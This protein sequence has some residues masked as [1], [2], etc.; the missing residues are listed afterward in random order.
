MFDSQDAEFTGTDS[1]PVRAI[2]AVSTH[3]GSRGVIHA[4]KPH[5]N[6]LITL[7]FVVTA[8]LAVAVVGM[9]VASISLGLF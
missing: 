1:S 4:N 6:R 2:R 5:G 8:V 7:V 3:S 9:L